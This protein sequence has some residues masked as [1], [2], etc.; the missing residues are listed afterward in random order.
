M[1]SLRRPATRFF[2][3]DSEL[4]QLEEMGRDGARLVTVWGPPGVGKT[5]LALEYAARSEARYPGGIW[6]LSLSDLSNVEDF[7]NSLS[8]SFDI[9]LAGGEP[10]DVFAQRMGRWKKT[11]VVLDGFDRLVDSA[12]RWLQELLGRVARVDALVTSRQRLKLPLET[13]CEIGPLGREA[14]DLFIDRAGL[15]D[16]DRDGVA[17]VVTHLD[18]IPLGIEV[19]AAHV[20]LLGLDGLEARLK[21]HLLALSHRGPLESS[22]ATLRDT[23]AWAW[24]LLGDRERSVLTQLAVF[25]GPF[26]VAA[27][28]AVLDVNGDVLGAISELRDRS[29]VSARGGGRL[30][31][32]GTVRRFATEHGDSAV[33]CEA[34]ERHRSYYLK[35]GEEWAAQANRGDDGSAL[36]RLSEEVSNLRSIALQDCGDE[37]RWRQAARAAVAMRELWM[38]RGPIGR[39]LEVLDGLVEAAP[40][41]RPPL[42]GV[43]LLARGASRRVN[44]SA[45]EARTDLE[46]AAALLAGSAEHE[47]RALNELAVF[48]HQQRALD[49]AREYYE[50]ALEASEPDSGF[51]A[52]LEG[53]LGA[54]VHDAGDFDRAL[55]H[56]ERALR[57]FRRLGLVRMEAIFLTNL[58]LLRQET[59]ALDEAAEDYSMALELLTRVADPRFEATA[60]TNRGLLRVMTGEHSAALEDQTVALGLFTEVGDARSTALAHARLGI[61][62]ALLGQ[63]HESRRSFDE[64]ER[65]L[66]PMNQRLELEF[67]ELSRAFRDLEQAQTA[68]ELDDP[69]GCAR[70]RASVQRRIRAATA[71]A[72]DGPAMVDVFDDAR[73]VL[74]LLRTHLD[75]LESETASH[76]LVVSPDAQRFRPPGGSWHDFGRKASARRI[77]AALVE[78]HQNADG[79]AMDVDAIFC[80]GWGDQQISAESM[81]NRVY[82]ALS[83]LRKRGLGP[84]LLRGDDGYYLDPAVR[85]VESA[86]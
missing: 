66:G 25:S 33:L 36:E 52:N 23:I 79:G 38:S 7:Q 47:G 50:R 75:S 55:E 43:V 10:I 37:K 68:R 4:S 22:H 8:K 45:D 1:S 34:T 6:P 48:H 81:A 46:S 9:N 16:V 84:L 19:A 69:E 85:I 42:L 26:T 57:E 44:R 67:V 28:E 80:A 74:S 71:P 24:D 61:A 54:L 39:Y 27:A 32:Y 49:L 70:H 86:D 41:S 56:Y 51:R 63:R 14:E 76:V 53:N 21:D 77:F 64:A 78:L 73:I 30:E 83:D 65:I 59:G 72:E 15:S 12:G 29:F 82:V 20:D 35:L 13:S 62:Q 2:G 3:R 11:L 40:A 18:R 5:R 60:R 17:R 31:C 58:A